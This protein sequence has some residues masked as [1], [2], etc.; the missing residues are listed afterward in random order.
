[1]IKL[2]KEYLPVAFSFPLVWA[3]GAVIVTIALDKAG[4]PSPWPYVIYFIIGTYCT[5]RTFRS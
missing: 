1:M 2:I 3:L 4:L 5:L